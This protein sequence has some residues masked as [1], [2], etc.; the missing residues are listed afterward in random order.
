MKEVFT[1]TAIMLRTPRIG[2]RL[3]DRGLT[4]WF[5]DFFREDRLLPRSTWDVRGMLPRRYEEGCF[6]PSVDTYVKDNVLH[7]RAELPG[8]DLK[9]VDVSLEGT[10][11]TISGERKVDH[12]EEGVTCESKEIAYGEFCRSFCVPDGIDAEKIHAS[13][14]NGILHVTVPLPESMV[15][16]HIPIKVKKAAIEEKSGEAVAA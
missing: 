15:E 13:Y 14:E 10:T 16:K 6:C 8:M 9:D 7:L 3:F 4:D 11:L 5:D 2:R 1:M 12:I